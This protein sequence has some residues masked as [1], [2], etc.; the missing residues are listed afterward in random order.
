M[1]NSIEVIRP[2]YVRGPFRV[3]VFDFDGTVSLL[4]AGWQ[5]LMAE[6]MVGHLLGTGTGETRAQL[7]A[8]TEA[9]ILDLTGRPTIFQ[10]IRLAEELSKRGKSP[11]DPREYKEEYQLALRT[12]IQER[13]GEIAA[14]AAPP[15]HWCLAGTHELL[16]RLEAH[17]FQL[18]LVSGTEFKDVRPEAEQLD[19]ARYFGPRIYGPTGDDTGFNKRAVLEQIL[20][21]EAISGDQLVGFG[22]GPAETEE[23]RRIG[24][25]AIGVASEE[26]LRF[27][28]HPAKRRRLIEAGA[29]WIIGDYADLE[30]LWQAL[31]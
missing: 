8:L 13:L 9:F 14:E 18:Y 10:M 31:N 2:D 28:I 17:D 27:G 23:V 26:E 11:R 3:A 5:P 24:G 4:R 25:L 20:R 1:S 7:T 30:T 16:D 12:R 19:L 15:S 22:D 29:D 21:D 6:L